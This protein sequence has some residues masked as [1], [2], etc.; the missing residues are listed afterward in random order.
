MDDPWLAMPFG[1]INTAGLV[2]VVNCTNCTAC[3]V[4]VQKYGGGTYLVP[5]LAYL[6]IKVLQPW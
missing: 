6:T 2:L 3:R 1:D 5:V 4:L